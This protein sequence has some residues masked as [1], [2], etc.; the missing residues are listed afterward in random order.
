M[1]QQSLVKVYQCFEERMKGKPSKQAQWQVA[2]TYCLLG[3]FL[4]PE[5]G[6]NTFH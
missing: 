5:D 3:L 1:I 4:N 6:S 2:T